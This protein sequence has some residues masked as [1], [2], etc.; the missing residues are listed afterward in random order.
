MTRDPDPPRTT[1]RLFAA[2]VFVHEADAVL[3][4]ALEP[5]WAGRP[6]V[7]CAAAPAA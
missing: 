6:T 4:P 3:G 2:V 7:N 1:M 5:T